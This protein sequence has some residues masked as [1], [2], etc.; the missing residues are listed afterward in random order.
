LAGKS[1]W[2]S[3]SDCDVTAECDPVIKDIKILG[4]WSIKVK[5]LVRRIVALSVSAPEEKCLVFSQYPEALHLIKS[6][7]QVE[8]VGLVELLGGRKG[9]GRAVKAFLQDDSARVFLLSHRAGA[10]GLTLVRANHVFLLEPALDPAI[11]QQAIA[12]VHRIGQRRNVHVVRLQLEGTIESEVLAIQ[13]GRH[14]LFQE[15]KEFEELGLQCDDGIEVD[16]EAATTVSTCV[17]QE[18]LGDEDAARLI[19][20]VLSGGGR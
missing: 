10:Q 11:E 6:A 3:F 18:T 7:L 19:G 15:E 20:A 17:R 14:A 5:A 2:R 13:G 16:V 9:M 8:G 4:E 1:S 12:R